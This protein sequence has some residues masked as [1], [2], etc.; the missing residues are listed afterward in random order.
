MSTQDTGYQREAKERLGLPYELLS[1]EEGR[2]GGELGLPTFEWEGKRVLKRACL[3]V[4]AGRVVKWWY[5][6]FP[7]GANVDLVLAWLEE[8]R[9]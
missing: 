6:V 3:A 8:G 7:S 2:L 1:D 9:E 4:E 5:P